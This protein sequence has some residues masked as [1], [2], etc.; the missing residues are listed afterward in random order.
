[1]KMK[2]FLKKTQGLQSVPILQ[3]FLA[4]QK[5]IFC[6]KFAQPL[7]NL[8]QLLNDKLLLKKKKKLKLP[9]N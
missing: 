4:S 5:Y 3:L 9:D 8:L 2:H 6:A 7:Q 1:M